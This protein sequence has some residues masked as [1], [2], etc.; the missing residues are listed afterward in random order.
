MP[1]YDGLGCGVVLRNF[2]LAFLSRLDAMYALNNPGLLAAGLNGDVE[3]KVSNDVQDARC[4][5]SFS[6]DLVCLSRALTG[7]ACCWAYLS[8]SWTTSLFERLVSD[9]QVSRHARS[10]RILRHKLSTSGSRISVVVPD[11]FL[12][13]D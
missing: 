3:T 11:R 9:L 13:L 7:R 10:A 8:G 5:S 6:I 2:A 12:H 4:S 1:C